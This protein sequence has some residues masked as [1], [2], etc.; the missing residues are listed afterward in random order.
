MKTQTACRVCN[1][2]LESI[3]SLGEQYISNF[4]TPQQPDGPKA[5]LE[6]VL[7][8]RCRL[9][10]LRH[11]VPAEAMYKNYWYRSGTNQTM[12]DAL[13]D[14][15][16][17]AGSLTYLQEGDSVLD[18]GCNDGTLLASY[19]T[20]GIY[21]IGFDP[22]ENLAVYSRKIADKL[23][24]GFF[25]SEAFYL[26]P[27]LSGRRP[28]IVTSIAMFY[29]LEDPN[30]FVADI[31]KVMHPEGL[32]IVQMSYLLLMLKTNDFGNICHEHLE[33]YSLQSFEYLLNLH[34]FV[35]VDV[36]LND[37]NG[38]SFRAYIRNRSADES[39]F[40][41][42]SYRREAQHRVSA[43]RE[44]EAKMGL[45]KIEPYLEFATRVER[46][47]EDVYGF[48]RDHVRQNERVYV[49]G[50]ST[51]GNTMLQYFGLDN[52][53]ISA[54]A[55]RN[56]DKWGKVT[57]GTRIPIVS[58]AEAR[59]AKPDFFLVLPWHFVDEFTAREKD[60][61]SSSG[62]F[63]VPLPHFGLI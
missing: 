31:K 3:F 19:E 34:D 35:L 41:S 49:Y 20:N 12:R 55:E 46:V 21:R 8:S 32:W 42:E 39:V 54:A 62:R 13:A 27:E 14:I 22:A 33:Y 61:L 59:A 1:S 5:P 45:D 47:K 2:S 43:L 9:L 29:D 44:K 40:G 60:Y 26:D 36:E 50:A 16:K 15:A 48:I 10:Q 51:K 18:I 28:K 57:V 7:C 37:V 58:E 23:V 30:R 6:L 53:L 56:P 25:E 11:T 38:G 52:S 63:I 4:L 24:A 17:K